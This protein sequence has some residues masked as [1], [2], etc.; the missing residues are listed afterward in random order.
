MSLERLLKFPYNGVVS[1]LSGQTKGELPKVEASRGMQTASSYS[2]SS[3]FSIQG[4]EVCDNATSSFVMVEHVQQSQ[5]VNDRDAYTERV[6]SRTSAPVSH[7]H[8]ENYDEE[9]LEAADTTADLQQ[10]LG[11]S[12]IL[13]LNFIK[14]LL[15][16]TVISNFPQNSCEE[17]FTCKGDGSLCWPTI[18]PYKVSR[19]IPTSHSSG[20]EI[21]VVRELLSSLAETTTSDKSPIS[22]SQKDLQPDKGMILH[23]PTIEKPG[24]PHLH[25]AYNDVIHVIR[26]SSFRFGSEQPVMDTVEMVFQN[27]NVG[28][29]INVVSDDM[30]IRNGYFHDYGNF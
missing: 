4:F 27:V 16:V 20:D 10:I 30:E 29:L 2:K 21:Y 11:K 6:I 13:V 7:V 18:T 19:S 22:S 24:S 28:K 1:H 12:L 5:P 3:S 26:L 17:I 8:C 25:S 23:H 14:F 9:P 15:I